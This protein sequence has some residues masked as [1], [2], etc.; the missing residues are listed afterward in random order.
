[1]SACASPTKSRTGR[2]AGRA[3]GL[4]VRCSVLR[5]R[6]RGRQRALPRQAW[7]QVYRTITQLLFLV[8]S[9]QWS[10]SHPSGL[11]VVQSVFESIHISRH[12]SPYP[13]DR[14]LPWTGRGY[15]HAERFRVLPLLDLST[16]EDSYALCGIWAN[17]KSFLLARSDRGTAWRHSGL[18]RTG[19][20]GRIP[21]SSEE[22]L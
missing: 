14:L 20:S 2:R 5:P 1:M 17:S 18:F 6:G 3:Y 13:L 8:P 22:L 4:H 16:P 10:A 7:F 9:M 19:M 12:I 11:L 21:I 15:K